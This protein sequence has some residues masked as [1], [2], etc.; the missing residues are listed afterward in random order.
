M[1]TTFSPTLGPTLS[2]SKSNPFNTASSDWSEIQATLLLNAALA[3]ALLGV[4][5]FYGGI[6]SVY[7]PKPQRRSSS[8][9][10]GMR[11]FRDASRLDDDALGKAVG[12]DA[13]LLIRFLRAWR[14]ITTV[15]CLVAAVVL[16]PCYATGRRRD[17]GFYAWTIANVKKGAPRN[18]AAVVFLYFFTLYALRR[19]DREARRYAKMRQDYLSQFEDD[20][21]GPQA[22][23]SVF[24]ERVPRD[25]RSD[26]ALATYFRRLARSDDAVH[27]AVV[28]RDC[29]VLEQVRKQ[30][31]EAKRALD[32]DTGTVYR[33]R[34]HVDAVA[35]HGV[36][37]L[38]W[39]ACDGRSF[40]STRLERLDEELRA[41]RALAENYA[42]ND[43]P[44]SPLMSGSSL[45]V[46]A[47]ETLDNSRRL[48]TT[49]TRRVFRTLALEGAALGR[50][51]EPSATGVV[52][53]SSVG[54]A[55]T[56]GQ[57]QLASFKGLRAVAGVAPTRSDV[58]FSNVGE[59]ASGVEF[60][61]WCADALLVWFGV[62]LTPLIGVIQGL[63]NIE[64]IAEVVP[65]LRPFAEE[66][67]YAYV[68]EVVTGYIPVLLVLGLL[69]IIPYFL[70]HLALHYVR[71]K[72]QSLVQR[73]V[74]D[75]H[76]YFQLLAIFVTVLSGS[77]ADVVKAFVDDPSSIE[78]LLGRSIPGVGA[79]FLQLLTVK[80][81]VSLAVEAARP[82]PLAQ[83]LSLRN[84][85]VRNDPR[86]EQLKLG[87][88]V[89]QILMVVLVAVLYAAIA[90]L[91]LVP[92]AVYFWLAE[93]VYRKQLLLVYTKRSEGG[94]AA[95]F[96]AL[97]CF[98]ALS[99]GIGQLV[100]FSYLALS[101]AT[102]EHGD[103][104]RQ[105]L[106]VLPLPVITFA[107]WRRV[108]QRYIVPAVHLHRDAA[109]RRDLFRDLSDRLAG[110]YY[111][112]PALVDD[113]AVA[114]PRRASSRNEWNLEVLD[115]PELARTTT[116]L[117]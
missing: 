116:P 93:P 26:D 49:A 90:P 57:I 47:Q 2:P 50:A 36:P 5:T 98:S 39:R 54:V 46:R 115:E 82:V 32:R 30:R 4:A 102:V 81:T 86:S 84:L 94:G 112:Q 110:T 13:Q 58:V 96:P 62:L 8:V 22:R 92:A 64:R 20:D 108:V 97:A 44:T 18:W 101:D 67:E 15:G 1:A 9:R 79:Y 91:I 83:H 17:S 95:L 27:S 43:E 105:A 74:L 73:Y 41:G 52:T 51:L 42:P 53:F 69:A 103:A 85:N 100:L 16:L 89:P 35:A 29:R 55:A 107:H 7:A 37:R 63:S 19:A 78:T 25:L 11:G 113:G 33:A 80:A 14:D 76:F 106:A 59:K 10:P 68:R 48:A 38:W 3:A 28:F 111:R 66:D 72:S 34:S 60:R 109:T 61:S 56:I 65:F 71:F 114:P 21:D 104:W 75:R 45:E 88:V 23:C 99:L 40:W 6:A 70:E 117:V 12:P 87:H 77:L 31:D 24:V